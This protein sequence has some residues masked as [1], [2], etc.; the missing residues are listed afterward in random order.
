MEKNFLI[1]LLENNYQNNSCERLELNL[2]NRIKELRIK[3]NL[4]QNNLASELNI[5]R[6]TL[7]LIERNKLTPS[8]I[9]AMRISTF[10]S[11]NVES[12]FYFEN[13]VIS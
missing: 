9:I 7:S 10:F 11:T 4:T 6:Q 1:K 2:K 13:E 3:C 8:I 12:I 5:S